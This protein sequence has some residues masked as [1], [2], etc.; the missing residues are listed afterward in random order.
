MLAATRGAAE[1]HPSVKRRVTVG[2]LIV[3]ELWS[4]KVRTGRVFFNVVRNQAY[5][6]EED[7]EAFTY[8]LVWASITPSFRSPKQK[9]DFRTLNSGDACRTMQ[10]RPG[11][12]QN[13]PA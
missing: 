10:P 2:I 11:L 3:A 6:Y 13:G 4:K 5:D 1:N 9:N 12:S 7:F 8:E